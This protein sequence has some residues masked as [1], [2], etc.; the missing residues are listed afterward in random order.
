MRGLPGALELSTGRRWQAWDAMRLTC[1][2]T[3]GL[4]FTS[5]REHVS[6]TT[7]IANR[8]S[9]RLSNEGDRLIS[10]QFGIKKTHLIAAF[11][12]LNPDHI[13]HTRR[14]NKD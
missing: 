7:V 13:P 4:I 9:F 5:R 2:Y 12:P 14:P 11:L 3:A 6:P 1:F 8:L 10:N